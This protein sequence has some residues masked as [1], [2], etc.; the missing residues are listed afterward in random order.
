M[1]CGPIYS[2]TPTFEARW[3]SLSTMNALAFLSMHRASEANDTRNQA[4]A[5]RM[6]VLSTPST[7]RIDIIDA[8]SAF[9]SGPSMKAIQSVGPVVTWACFTLSIRRIFSTTLLGSVALICTKT[10]AAIMV[11]TAFLYFNLRSSTPDWS[12]Q[13]PPLEEGRVNC[14]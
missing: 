9:M 10:Y 7:A 1:G 14:G 3:L 11:N 13:E 6:S 12:G 8:V 4:T 5:G 2:N